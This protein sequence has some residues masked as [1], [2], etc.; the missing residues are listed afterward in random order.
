MFLL[1]KTGQGS[2]LSF[3]FGFCNRLYEDLNLENDFHFIT[4]NINVTIPSGKGTK[5][6]DAISEIEK[7]SLGEC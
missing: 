6:L 1:L 4:Y 5:V 2:F 3:H 7:L